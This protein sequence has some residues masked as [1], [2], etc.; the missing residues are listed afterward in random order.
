MAVMPA[1]HADKAACA[2]QA[3]LRV[4]A[5]VAARIAAPAQLRESSS[6]HCNVLDA[7]ALV[8]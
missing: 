5:A 2:A 3:P 4:A 8:S 7:C 6:A 1:V